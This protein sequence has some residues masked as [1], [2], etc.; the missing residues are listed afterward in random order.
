MFIAFPSQVPT[1]TA[2]IQIFYLLKIFPMYFQP[3]LRS[4]SP[5]FIT[6]G[7]LKLKKNCMKVEVVLVTSQVGVSQ[8]QLQDL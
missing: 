6:R 8:H 7:I 4:A 2:K 3:L 5:D 1:F